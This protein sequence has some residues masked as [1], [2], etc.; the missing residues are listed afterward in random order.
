MTQEIRTKKWEGNIPVHYLY[1]FGL[2]GEKFFREIKD[3][4]MFVGTKCDACNVTYVP[5]KIYCER[6]FAEL[7]QYVDVGMNG[8]VETFTVCREAADGTHLPEPELIAY[9]RID[10]TDGGLVHRLTGLKRDAVKI[11]MKVEAVFADPVKRTG[12]IGDVLGFRPV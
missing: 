3:R 11:G 4:G 7:A 8:T 9:V 6:C 10:G 5:P 12:G 1:T 2:A